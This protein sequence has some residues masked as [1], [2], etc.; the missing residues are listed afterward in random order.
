MMRAWRWW[1]RGGARRGG[2]LH[3]EPTPAQIR[4]ERLSLYLDGDLDREAREA[5]ERELAADA[6]ARAALEGMREV[7]EALRALGSEG[8][9]ALRAPRPFTLAEP[10]RAAR[11]LGDPAA[12]LGAL[13]AALAAFAFVA[14]VGI[15][16]GPGL[17]GRGGEEM[18]DA[19]AAAV[20]PAASAP[21][22]AQPA[23]AEAQAAP[24]A[25]ASS[26][27]A[28]RPE[29]ERAAPA[30]EAADESAPREGAAEEGEP[31]SGGVLPAGAAAPLAAASAAAAAAALALGALAL[32]RRRRR[33]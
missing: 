16:V 21:Q 25:D 1:R 31:R 22:A 18:A 33:I 27:Q 26:A 30:G 11:G 5:L 17:E 7:T 6:G 12:R 32:R 29:A 14:A 4:D 24:L 20:A 28:D 9:G 23:A 2:D 10:P 15:A 3:A 19:P 8:T 13:A